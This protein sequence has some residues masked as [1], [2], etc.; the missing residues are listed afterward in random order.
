MGKLDK[1][2]LIEIPCNASGTIY[3][4]TVAGIKG[5]VFAVKAPNCSAVNASACGCFIAEKS[6][7][8]NFANIA[9]VISAISVVD[10][11]LAAVVV[12]IC[13]SSGI[14]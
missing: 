9:G 4:K 12:A 10:V 11:N 2:S 14:G 1:A 13:K 3:L 8:V 7:L 5:N 6:V